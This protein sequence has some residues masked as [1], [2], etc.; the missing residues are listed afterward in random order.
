VLILTRKL[1]EAVCIGD[2][3]AVIVTQIEPNRVS[4]GI[5]APESVVITRPRPGDERRRKAENRT[6]TV[7]RAP[8]E[9]DKLDVRTLAVLGTSQGHDVRLVSTPRDA[10]ERQRELY[11]QAGWWAL[12]VGQFVDSA[13]F[14]SVDWHDEIELNR[15]C[16]Q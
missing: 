14:L 2:D 10:V 1:S 12:P 5:E 16:Q 15:R 8:R 13:P 3:V 4:I 7:T 6:L 9:C 11:G